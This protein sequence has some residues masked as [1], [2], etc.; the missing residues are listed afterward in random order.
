MENGVPRSPGLVRSALAILAF[1]QLAIGLWALLS[2]SGWY[3]NF[4]GAG[5]H[6]L[7]LYGSFDEH[8]A[9]DVG[10]AFL[11]LGV[12]LALAAV[13][14]DRRLVIAAAAGYLV[15]QVPHFFFHI[16][17]DDVLSGADRFANVVVFSASVLLAVAIIVAM[18][19]PAAAPGK[20][21][22]RPPGE[23][24]GR[25]GP[26]PGGLIARAARAYG[27]RNYGEELA[28]TDAFLHHKRLLL[29]YGAFELSVLGS[30]RVDERLKLLAEMK[31]AAV[32]GCEWCMDFGSKL[33]RDEGIPD[34]QLHEL[35]IYR[36]SDAFDERERLVLDY[37]AAI[38]RTPAEVGDDLVAKLRE[39]FDDGQLV[40]L[41][42][43]IALENMRARFNHALGFEPQGFSEGAACVVP[44]LV[45]GAAGNGA[46]IVTAGDR[47]P[48]AP[49]AL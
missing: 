27:R 20:A 35:P 49:D 25:L 4:P 41:T 14:M 11:A 42:N 13:W 26:P 32:V 12:I 43:V 2:P 1:P 31:A 16:G 8:L 34:R 18:R 3:E 39:H 40:E 44:E 21:R 7:P 38:S 29:G 45:E 37:A 10:S 15:Y 9:I 23:G 24:V 30:H 22:H 6:W 17:A 46:P 19:R 47:Q 5:K 28:P 48:R 36:T 33:S